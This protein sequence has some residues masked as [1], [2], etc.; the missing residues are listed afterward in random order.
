[1]GRREWPQHLYTVAFQG[2]DLWGDAAEPGTEVRVDL[3][4]AYLEA[5]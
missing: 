4:E 2:G 3:F 5:A 1:V